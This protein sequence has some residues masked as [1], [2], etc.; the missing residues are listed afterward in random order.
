[1]RLI[2]RAVLLQYTSTSAL[3]PSSS[4]CCLNQ[5]EVMELASE[6]LVP[7]KKMYVHVLCSCMVILFN[8]LVLTCFWCP[9]LGLEIQN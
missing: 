1:M 4:S 6:I 7:I 3:T 2:Q 5:A 8:P 9:C